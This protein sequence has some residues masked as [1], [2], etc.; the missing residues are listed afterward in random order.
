MEQVTPTRVPIKIERIPIMKERLDWDEIHE[1][2]VNYIKFAARSIYNQFQ[3]ESTDD[4]FQEGQLLM[5]RCW[6]LYGN[7]PI[8]EFG[9]IFKASLWRKLREIS[10]KKRHSTVDFD[11]LIEAGLE[12]GYEKDID[13][14]IDESNRFHQLI[15]RLSEQPIALTILKEFIAPGDR[16]LWEMQMEQARKQTLH[17][18]N[19]AVVAPNSIQPSKKTI[20]RGMEISMSK[21][22]QHF[23]IL[24]NIMRDIYK[25]KL[26]QTF[27]SETL[28]DLQN[29]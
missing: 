5:Y 27:Q 17:N 21:F 24:K 15:D 11:T 29:I 26:T 16:T 23:A 3:T 13:N 9:P 10:G 22:D 2:F 25:D 28:M 19:Y 8:E 12:P 20:R 1:K 14:E 18:Q 7:K 6:L 4:L